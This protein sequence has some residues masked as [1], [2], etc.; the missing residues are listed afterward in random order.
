MWDQIKT[1]T[2]AK[3]ETKKM[4]KIKEKYIYQ[5]ELNKNKP[6]C[7]KILDDVTQEEYGEF[8]KRFP[9]VWKTAW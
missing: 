4:K 9:N 3:Q 8:Y 6:I 2:V 5:E 1:M 7:I